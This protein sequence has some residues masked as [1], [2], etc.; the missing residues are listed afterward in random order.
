MAEAN[1]NETLLFYTMRKNELAVQISQLQ[2]QKT[3][4]AY[5]QA[6][7]SSIKAQDE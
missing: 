5:S 3:L 6:D 2:S 1:L 7:A 4:A